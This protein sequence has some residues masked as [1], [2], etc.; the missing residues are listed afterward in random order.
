MDTQT[1]RDVGLTEIESGVYLALLESGSSH[2]G[3]IIKK[4]GLHK[5]TIYQT[6]ERLLEKGLVGYAIE[7]NIKTFYAV[8]P[9]VILDQLKEKEEN[10]KKLLP[11]LKHKLE[12][13]KKPV[14]AEIFRGKK[15]II[16]VYRDILS[17]NE[18]FNLGA[19]IPIVE[20]L[21]P[22]FYQIQKIK[23]K[24]KIKAKLLISEKHRGTSLIQSLAG[25]FRY[26][27]KEFEGPINTVIYGDKVAIIV[28]SD[29]MAFVLESKETSKAYK[30][31]FDVLWKIA[32][33]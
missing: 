22:F 12:T 13:A 17:Y 27:P 1:F 25:E 16:T 8:N 5:A 20:I 19:G 24:R 4:T 11:D 14:F 7:G 28:W 6:L 32:K 29:L 18:Y 30:K 23:Q 26:L 31:Y 3:L 33:S 10:F 2:V 21:G 15:G 9:E